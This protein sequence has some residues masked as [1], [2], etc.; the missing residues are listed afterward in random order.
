MNARLEDFLEPD[1]EKGTFRAE[2]PTSVQL[3]NGVYK[4]RIQHRPHMEVITHTSS[5]E[6]PH[7]ILY[8]TTARISPAEPDAKQFGFWLVNYRN[9]MQRYAEGCFET[10][11]LSGSRLRR[12]YEGSLLGRRKKKNQVAIDLLQSWLEEKPDEQQASDLARLKE[13]IDEQRIEDRKL[14]K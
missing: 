6:T 9:Q 5:G 7:G 8:Y 12:L 13:A 3:M 2:F 11:V 10:H 1:S 14:F 4:R